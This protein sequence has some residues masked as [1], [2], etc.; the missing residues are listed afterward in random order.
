VEVTHDL[1]RRVQLVEHAARE[2]EMD[3]A[4]RS[5]FRRY[6]SIVRAEQARP[7][8]DLINTAAERPGRTKT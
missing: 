2:P 8:E 6:W 7:N 1:D 3:A 5:R 4:D